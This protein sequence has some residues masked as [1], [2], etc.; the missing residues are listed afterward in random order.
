MI[1]VSPPTYEELSSVAPYKFWI[2]YIH[3]DFE[4]H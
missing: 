2:P 4:V 1:V 3:P